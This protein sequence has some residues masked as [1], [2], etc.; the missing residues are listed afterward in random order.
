MPHH[1]QPPP[2]FRRSISQIWEHTLD[3]FL[4]GRHA[5]EAREQEH[6]MMAHIQ[7]HRDSLRRER[8]M[9]RPILG[10]RFQQGHT[11]IWEL[12]TG[13]QNPVQGPPTEFEFLSK[14]GF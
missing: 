2:N 4:V 13:L 12:Y 10:T 9:A 11:L 1:N 14:E 3:S 5:D 7:A 6:R 8:L